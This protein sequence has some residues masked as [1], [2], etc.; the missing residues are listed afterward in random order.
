MDSL[1]MYKTHL[2]LLNG[3]LISD[4]EEYPGFLIVKSYLNDNWYDSIT[5]TDPDILNWENLISKADHLNETGIDYA[6]YFPSEFRDALESPISSSFKRVGGD[7]YLL[8]KKIPDLEFPISKEI[9]I[10]AVDTESFKDYKDLIE[11]IHGN[12]MGWPAATSFSDRMFKVQES[13]SSNE[14]QVELFVA[15]INNRPVGYCSTISSKELNIT[16][17]TASGV[18]SEFRGKGIF[19]SIISSRLRSAREQGIESAYII[20]GQESKSWYVAKKLGYVEV[21]N[22]EYY[23]RNSS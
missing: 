8:L 9:Q 3:I 14:K 2:N 1:S 13:N 17:L 18:L 7:T 5:I 22:F 4:I 11:E 15:Y 20:T 10:K 12:E 19:S 23:L 16:Y 6:L 21:G